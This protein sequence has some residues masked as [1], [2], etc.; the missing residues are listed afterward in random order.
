MAGSS[1]STLRTTFL[2]RGVAVALSM[3]SLGAAAPLCAEPFRFPWDPP[4][5]Q[6]VKTPQK[7]PTQP[8]LTPPQVRSVLE[9]EGARLVG[10]P[11]RRGGEIVAVG[12][13]SDGGRRKFTL[14]ANG[15]VLNVEF[16]APTEPAPARE[17]RRSVERRPEFYDDLRALERP[18]PAPR[19]SPEAPDELP[20]LTPV[21]PAARPVK[22]GAA[23]APPRRADSADA[24]LSPIKPLRPSGA[25]KIEPLPQ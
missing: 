7:Q 5:R 10:A 19:H 12:R 16:L 23:A 2:R 13:D 6:P 21:E 18:S 15:R 24:S 8:Q 20:Q 17:P 9:R 1:S 3:L 14:D 11:Q 25:P 4:A 22:A